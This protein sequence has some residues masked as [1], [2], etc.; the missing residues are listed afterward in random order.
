MYCELQKICEWF[1]ANK[2]SSNVTKSDWTLFHKNSTKDKLTLKMPNLKTGNSTIKRKSSA[3][4]LRVMLNENISWK[5][6]KILLYCIVQNHFL[7]KNHTF[8]IYSFIFK[9]PKHCW[10]STRIFRLTL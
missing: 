6:P 9:L 4:F 3:K 1:R 2:L 10:A 7:M 5:K 8:L